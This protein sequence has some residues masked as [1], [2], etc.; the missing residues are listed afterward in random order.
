MTKTFFV[1]E[2]RKSL[3]KLTTGS[4]N[5]RERICEALPD[6]KSAYGLNES[7]F[8]NEFDEIKFFFELNREN[9]LESVSDE[10]LQ[11]VATCI[12]IIETQLSD[13]MDQRTAAIAR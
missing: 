4:G 10:T 6:I 7:F 12:F 1:K 3:F 5:L 2:I 9:G 8:K 13:F 11:K